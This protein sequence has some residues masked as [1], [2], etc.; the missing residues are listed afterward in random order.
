MIKYH[1]IDVESWDRREQYE[2]FR[3]Y[4]NPFFGLTA[5]VDVSRLLEYVREKG[6]SMFA[7][8]LYASQQQVNRIS[9][10]R[11]RILDNQVVEYDN[12]SAGSTVLKDNDVFTFC[13]FNHLP[14]FKDFHPHVIER[15]KAC[16]HPKTKL[17]DH[18]HNQAMIH[19]SVIP[20]VHFTAV[21]HPRNHGTK[22]SVPKI[23]FGKFEEKQ[24]STNLPISV[25]VHHGLLDGF[26][27]GL[28]FE[29]FQ[30][31]INDPEAL[32]EG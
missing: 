18:E 29:G 9:E 14:S 11:Y 15:I 26:H 10:F 3:D 5:N 7:A 25:E 27:V 24:A 16:R 22:D 28:Y 19:Y 13:Y 8:Y 23:M 20:W 30:N 12:I 17:T 21:T 1:P 2:F 4:D 31:S 6:Y 32:L